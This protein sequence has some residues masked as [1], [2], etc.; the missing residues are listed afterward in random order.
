[1][2][3]ESSLISNKN[4]KGVHRSVHAFSINTY[5]KTDELTF[6]VS[7]D[8]YQKMFKKLPDSI[9]SVEGAWQTVSKKV[10]LSARKWGEK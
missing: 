6:T 4:Q 3:L 7:W 10:N 8:L 1:M 5:V 9:F 2:T